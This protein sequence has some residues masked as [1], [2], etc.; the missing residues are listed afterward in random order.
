MAKIV[1]RHSGDAALWTS[2]GVVGALDYRS[3]K[4]TLLVTL[5]RREEAECATWSDDRTLVTIGTREGTRTLWNAKGEL[6]AEVRGPGA[7]SADVEFAPSLKRVF[8]STGEAAVSVLGPGLE[9][10]LPAS[11]MALS[12]DEKYVACEVEQETRVHDAK[13]LALVKTLPGRNA[14]FHGDVLVVDESV[15]EPYRETVPTSVAY[16]VPSFAK[17]WRRRGISIRTD[18]TPSAGTWALGGKARQYA[19]FDLRTGDALATWPASGY[20]CGDEWIWRGGELIFIEGSLITFW[21]KQRGKTTHARECGGALRPLLSADGKRFV[22]LDGIWDTERRTLVN[23]LE[24]ADGMIYGFSRDGSLLIGIDPESTGL[25][26]VLAAWS[27][28]TGKI[29]WRTKPPR[30]AGDVNHDPRAPYVS[31]DTKTLAFVEQSNGKL[32]WVGV[33]VTE[34]GPELL[35][36]DERC[37]AG[38]ADLLEPENQPDG[39]PAARCPELMNEYLRVVSSGG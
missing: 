20:A 3:G 1:A 32:Y 23:E 17:R 30:H 13:T 35:V 16:A 21:S 5:P 8:L 38:A 14:Q 7:C 24:G 2:N 33:V 19:V 36:F 10:S 28:T 26:Q 25:D 29:V 18:R 12:A 11:W 27:T 31:M 9:G 15:Y 22:G 34:H 39:L 4:N 6:L 37:W